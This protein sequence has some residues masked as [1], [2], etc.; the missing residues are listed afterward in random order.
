MTLCVAWVR[1]AEDNEEL[2]FATDSALTGGEKWNSGIKLFELPRKDCLLCFAGSTF[3]AYPLILHL[4]SSIRFNT[5]LQDPHADIVEVLEYL[6]DL[7]TGLVKGVISEIAGEN[8][9]DMRGGAKFLFGG[10]SWEENRFRIWEL[11]YEKEVE[12]FVYKEHSAP[13]KSRIASFLGDPEPE[14]GQLALT[15]YR[16]LMEQGDFDRKLGMEPLM[17]LRDLARDKTKRE[18]DGSLQ[19]AKVY[20]SGTSEFFGVYWPSLDGFPCL[21]GQEFKHFDK[22]RVR[23]YDPDTFE[24]IEDQLPEHIGNL[25]ALNTLR[26]FA[27]IKD[28]YPMGALKDELTEKERERLLTAFRAHSYLKFID[29]LKGTQTGA[30][31]QEEQEG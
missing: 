22:P 19:I 15:A 25:E 12:G 7:F 29:D 10:W 5:E 8:L 14:V 28:C 26:D 2:V 17:V 18:V 27:F 3:R 21:Q 23:Y 13:E 1:Q 16:E 9:H 6:S 4:I 24:V 11:Y 31:L 30:D 20:R